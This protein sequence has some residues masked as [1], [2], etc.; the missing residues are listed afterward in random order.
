MARLEYFLVAESCSLDQVTNHV[1]MFDIIEEVHAALFP[2]VIPRVAAVA[3]LILD[4]SEMVGFPGQL[5][6]QR[7]G[8]GADA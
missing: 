4:S 2:V 3:C 5:A 6:R 7:L 1:S 8:G